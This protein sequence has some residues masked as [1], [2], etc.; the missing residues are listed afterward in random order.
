MQDAIKQHLVAGRE[1]YNGG[2]YARAR[3][4]LEAVLQTHD[5]FADI[6]NMLGVIAYE[7][8]DPR[9]ACASFE[10]AL[11]LN[12]Y[13][14]EAALNLAIIYNELG[15]YLDAKR[16]YAQAQGE[17]AGEGL[18]SLN[19]FV[20]GKIANM[21]AE[22]GDAYVAT[23][24]LQHAIREFRHALTLSPTF[25]DIRTKL[26][27]TL[28]DT[29]KVDEALDEFIGLRESAP[30]YLHARIHLGVTLWRAGRIAEARA[31]WS[32]VLDHDPGNRS[33]RVYLRMTADDVETP[34]GGSDS[35]DVPTSK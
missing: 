10:R 4:H 31:E 19:H 32:Y 9:S 35:G 18:E 14:T 8:G 28:R 1:F 33:C 12:P 11:I 22:L 15:R 13:Y 6:H 2:E 26:A 21:H 3:P 23:G 27:T 24:L 17:R 29:G 5:D 25:V 20:R 16:V 7:D 30:E 34:R